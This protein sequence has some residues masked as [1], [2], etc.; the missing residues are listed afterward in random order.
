MIKN[1]NDL[2]KSDFAFSGAN[3]VIKR[4]FFNYSQIMGESAVVGLSK[5]D[6]KQFNYS[7]KLSQQT[8]DNVKKFVVDNK[9]NVDSLLFFI[10]ES[11]VVFFMDK[12]SG[13]FYKCDSATNY[14]DYVIQHNKITK[15]KI[16]NVDSLNVVIRNRATKSDSLLNDFG[17]SL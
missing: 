10:R 7:F 15:D 5:S 14:A 1:V 17:L 8:I 6:K 13:L 11:S 4:G 16:V 2:T 12:S 9:L 3:Q